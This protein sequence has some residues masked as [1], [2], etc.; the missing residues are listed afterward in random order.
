MR[1]LNTRLLTLQ[2][3]GGTEKP[4]YAI[5]SHT[6]MTEEIVFQD[7]VDGCIKDESVRYKKALAKVHGAC[8][9]AAADNYA[10]IW[11]DSV[12]IDK[13]SSAELQ[14]AINSMWM[15]YKSA[16]V[17]YAYL[18]DVKEEETG[19]ETL[20][21]QYSRWFTRGWTLQELIA[22]TYLI[23]FN[24][25]WKPIGTKLRRINEIHKATGIPTEALETG[26]MEQHNAAEIM[27]WAAHR[28]VSREEDMAYCLMGLFDIN[29]PMLYGEGGSKAFLRL[30]EAV[31]KSWADDTL[32]LWMYTPSKELPALLAEN[33]NQFCRAWPCTRCGRRP[34]YRCFPMDI[35]YKAIQPI[36]RSVTIYQDYRPRQELSL[37]RWGVRANMVI[38]N[39]VK[40]SQLGLLK[41]RNVVDCGSEGIPEGFKIPQASVVVVLDVV[42]LR[43]RFFCFDMGPGRVMHMFQ[44]I[45]TLRLIPLQ[46]EALPDGLPVE[47]YTPVPGNRGCMC[48]IQL[49]SEQFKC[50]R[51]EY[52]IKG[53]RFLR[54]RDSI[55]IDSDEA[56]P[57]FSLEV[58][59]QFNPDCRVI[60]GLV[61]KGLQFGSFRIT[62]VQVHEQDMMITDPNTE[63][64]CTDE[65]FQEL[66]NEP[67][68][69]ISVRQQAG[70]HYCIQMTRKASE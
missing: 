61:H 21:V 49:Q 68:I 59:D 46:R 28:Q 42:D 16:C 7:F 65:Y 11:I 40:A 4:P 12:C 19:W 37:Q 60:V 25:D 62:S 39:L 66:N 18:E 53:T 27:S 50:H 10:W 33:P 47:I 14:E 15:W 3:F 54:Y 9:Q 58:Y 24:V 45:P 13:S 52:Q 23:F 56:S 64:L 34:G 51:W 36:P 44:R 26:D 35:P 70:F 20:E 31:Y 29:M 8:K 6:W 63:Y 1:L 38:V 57:D 55:S 67:S 30:Q 32:F 17:C 69:L 5:L 41:S 2:W 22:P 43:G 48:S